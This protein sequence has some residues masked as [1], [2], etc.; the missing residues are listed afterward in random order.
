L[1]NACFAHFG[2][3]YNHPVFMGMHRD[4]LVGRVISANHTH[5]SIVD[6]NFESWRVITYSVLPEPRGRSYE[7]AK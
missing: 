1:I 3:V 7:A 5:L 6:F 4:I 2:Q